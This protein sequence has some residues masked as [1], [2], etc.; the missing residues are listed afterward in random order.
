MQL[1]VQ[2]KQLDVGDALRDHIDDRLRRT[3]DK[4]F[5]DALEVNVTVSREAHRYKTVI[6]AHVG[7]GI[8]MEAHGE[9]KYE[10]RRKVQ[11]Q[12]VNRC[13]GCRPAPFF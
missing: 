6:A 8:H 1:S 11:W 3:L 5:G 9:A 10:C 2:G 12:S 13:I 7:R 4:Y